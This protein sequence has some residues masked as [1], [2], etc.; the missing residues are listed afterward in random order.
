MLY[1]LGI[2][3][4]LD[5]EEHIGMMWLAGRHFG[6]QCSPSFHG[7]LTHE[8][9][10]IL[11]LSVV[12]LLPL[13]LWRNRV[14]LPALHCQKT[15]HLFKFTN[16]ATPHSNTSIARDFLAHNRFGEI[17]EP[18]CR[19]LPKLAGLTTRRTTIRP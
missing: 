2:G 17:S 9:R 4:N 12:E 8:R 6:S 10:E 19:L 1:I 7:F 14:L 15:Q 5:W 13:A 11:I 16:T 18:T 3:L